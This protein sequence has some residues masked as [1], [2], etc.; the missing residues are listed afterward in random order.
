MQVT[1]ESG[2]VDKRKNILHAKIENL[3][4]GIK[5]ENKYT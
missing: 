5:E 3:G 4:Y 2:A 1:T